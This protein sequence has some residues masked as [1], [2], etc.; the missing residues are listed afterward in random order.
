M[1]DTLKPATDWELAGMIATYRDRR[2]P[3]EIC[4]SG[5]KRA[6]GRPTQTAAAISTQSLRGITLYE[7]TELV[8]SARAGTPLSQVEA[9]LAA[10]GQMLAFEPIDL[11]PT[12]GNTAGQQT[13]GA[14]FAANL[15]GARR[16]SAGAA[17]DHLLGMRGV[18][19]LAEEFKSGGR[20]MKNVTGYDVARG[21]CGSWGTLAV[22]TEVTFK[23]LPWPE[24]TATLVYT[25]LTDELAT[26][27]MQSALGT[28]FEVSG[29]AHLSAGLARRLRHDGLRGLDTPLTALRLE[30]FPHAVA[31]RREALREQL[32]ASGFVKV[33]ELDA[34]DSASFWNEMR[35]LSVLPAGRTHLWKISTTPGKGPKLVAAVRRHMEAEA[36]YDWSG[37]LV[38]LEVPETADAGAADI[39]RAVATHGGHATLI[40]AE[41]SVRAAVDVFHPLSPAVERLARGMKS[42]FDPYGI[43]NPGRMYSGL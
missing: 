4:G 24:D 25:G 1:S 28:P 22:M 40:R 8:M 32:K 35:Q 43:L 14:V 15:S 19:G 36:L 42:A 33:V 7:P 21:L 41:A 9:E 26:E 3:I 30:N 16:I 10:R 17:R 39:R 29:T 12:T 5:T 34:H 18:N 11:G 20:V 31:Y 23:V 38:W 6:I 2:T 13:I 27:L 37:G